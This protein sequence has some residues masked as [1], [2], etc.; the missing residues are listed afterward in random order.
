MKQIEPDACLITQLISVYS[1]DHG[2]CTPKIKELYAYRLN[3][4]STADSYYLKLTREP[5]RIRCASC[6]TP[7]LTLHVQDLIEFCRLDQCN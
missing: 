2:N 5:G 6:A 3:I 4:G 7:F 1:A